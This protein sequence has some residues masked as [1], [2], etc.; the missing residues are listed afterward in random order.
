M[1]VRLESLTYNPLQWP[2][3]EMAKMCR[4]GCWKQAP[5]PS[6]IEGRVETVPVP[7]QLRHTG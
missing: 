1:L 7:A 3:V 5:G 6:I 4:L 2:V